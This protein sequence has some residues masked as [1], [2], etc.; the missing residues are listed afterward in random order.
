MKKISKSFGL[1]KA[2]KQS[3]RH[4]PP[5]PCLSR[6][7]RDPDLLHENMGAKTSS[8]ATPTYYLSTSL[9]W[10]QYTFDKQSNFSL[11]SMAIDWHT[12]H[13]IF[14]L[15]PFTLTECRAA[16]RNQRKGR[17]IKRYGMEY[18]EMPICYELESIRNS[19]SKSLSW[20][21]EGNP[22]VYKK[23]INPVDKLCRIKF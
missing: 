3:K 9:D 7:P 13:L 23:H 1:S 11:P 4:I 15:Y 18:A 5:P 6:A 21:V 14:E 16:R 20:R 2:K 8:Q 22:H 10:M 17:I 19:K 12:H